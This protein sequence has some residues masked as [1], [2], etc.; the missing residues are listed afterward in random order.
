M[1]LEPWDVRDPSALLDEIAARHDMHAGL[2]V[3]GLVEDPPRQQRLVDST[4]AWDDRSPPEREECSDLIRSA[5]G[6]LPVV[7]RAIPPRHAY[8]TV[9][10]RGGRAII[11]PAEAVWLYGW[12]YA[13]HLQPVFQGD[14]LLVT[15]HGWCSFDD[16]SGGSAPRLAPPAVSSWG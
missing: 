7:P 3:V 5:V 1:D 13:N 9:V 15:D 2:V 6:R 11:G 16:D 4:V 14:L 8:T 12:R 10:C